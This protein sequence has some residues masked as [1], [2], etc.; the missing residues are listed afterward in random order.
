LHAIRVK[1][2]AITCAEIGVG[3]EL[4]PP[5][6]K[7]ELLRRSASAFFAAMEPNVLGFC[8]SAA[9]EYARIVGLRQGLGRPIA[10]LDAQIAAIARTARATLATRNL[11]DF[12]HLDL[13]LVNPYAA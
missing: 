8:R 13:A 11:K 7:K 9:G 2:V 1:E 5:G 3:I 4:L 6:E 12:D 10:V